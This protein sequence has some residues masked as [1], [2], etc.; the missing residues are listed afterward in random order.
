GR[1]GVRS[2]AIV[3]PERLTERVAGR[4]EELWSEK[5]GF[6]SFLSTVDHKR[7]GRNYCYTAF[8]LF[9]A[10][11]IEALFMRTQLAR[12][13]LSLVGPEQLNELFSM[14]GLTMLF[15]FV[16]AMPCRLRNY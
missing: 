13:D 16:T 5:P 1:R 2:V 12:P 8:L 9:V 11:G 14:P 7:I 15:F 4:L 3:G 6:G 10:A